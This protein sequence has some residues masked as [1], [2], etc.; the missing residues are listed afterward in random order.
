MSDFYVDINR[1]KGGKGKQTLL[2]D[3]KDPANVTIRKREWRT[4]SSYQGGN[5]LFGGINT[6]SEFGEFIV[7]GH[8]DTI[9]G[10]IDEQ[11]DDWR[12]HIVDDFGNN[13]SALGEIH[14][15]QPYPRRLK[16]VDK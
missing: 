6:D 3:D 8:V 4:M 2:F 10:N 13:L 12:K 14:F 7:S 16:G 11:H 15:W 5:A 9:S 1:L